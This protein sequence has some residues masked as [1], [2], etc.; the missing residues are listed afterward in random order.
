MRRRARLHDVEAPLHC[1]AVFDESV[2]LPPI[3]GPPVMRTRLVAL[4]RFMDLSTVELQVL[5]SARTSEGARPVELPEPQGR[6][7][8]RSG[9]VAPGRLRG[10]SRGGEGLDKSPGPGVLTSS[11]GSWRRFLSD[12]A[13]R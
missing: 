1:S 4:S 9:D 10:S 8:S 5:P 7:S 13:D 2:L 6:K 11:A 3:G 12:L